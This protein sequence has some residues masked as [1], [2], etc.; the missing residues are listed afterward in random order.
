MMKVGELTLAL[1]NCFLLF[2]INIKLE[3]VA[4]FSALNDKNIYIYETM[5]L[6]NRA[7]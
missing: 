7:I 3:F 5:H 6:K 1:L 4:H 2:F